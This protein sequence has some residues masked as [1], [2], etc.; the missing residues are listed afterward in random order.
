MHEAVIWK[1]CPPLHRTHAVRMMLSLTI[2]MLFFVIFFC[3]SV[4]KH[5]MRQSICVYFGVCVCVCVHHLCNHTSLRLI[6]MAQKTEICRYKETKNIK[7]LCVTGEKGHENVTSL[8]THVQC[9][10]IHTFIVNASYRI[11]ESAHDRRFSCTTP[12]L[13]IN[14]YWCYKF[15]R[16]L[17]M[18][19][20]E[21]DD[22]IATLHSFNVPLFIQISNE[23]LTWTQTHT[24]LAFRRGAFDHRYSLH[25]I[26]SR[27]L[28]EHVL[29]VNNSFLFDTLHFFLIWQWIRYLYTDHLRLLEEKGMKDFLKW[30]IF[31]NC[32]IQLQ[33]R[34]TARNFKKLLQN[35]DM[36]WI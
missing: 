23:T 31:L 13:N 32:L 10:C 5:T 17:C 18:R 26:G 27:I 11:G 25:L 3:S 8:I 29:Y 4:V 33:F 20:I 28:L 6:R 34:L 30:V 2:G 35:S 9:V 36:N 19:R 24:I 21:C 22:F 1:Y 12:H 16:R 15:L 14:W 7:L